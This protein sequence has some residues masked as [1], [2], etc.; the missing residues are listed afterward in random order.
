MKGSERCPDSH[1]AAVGPCGAQQFQQE[2]LTGEAAAPVPALPEDEDG[3]RQPAH[4]PGSQDTRSST[5]S[6]RLASP[7]VLFLLEAADSV[8]DAPQA[9]DRVLHVKSCSMHWHGSGGSAQPA[10]TQGTV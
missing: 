10:P 7:T 1:P 5:T 9:P 3:R 2:P 6:P 8:P 4:L